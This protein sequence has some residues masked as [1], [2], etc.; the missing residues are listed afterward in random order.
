MPLGWIILASTDTP[1]ASTPPTQ[2]ETER[3]DSCRWV[4][5]SISMLEISRDCG[6]ARGRGLK[7]EQGLR[8]LTE[9]ERLSQYLWANEQTTSGWLAGWLAGIPQARNA[10][11]L[12]R[13]IPSLSGI[14]L[15]STCNYLL[16]SRKCINLYSFI[17]GLIFPNCFLL[18]LKSRRQ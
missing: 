7:T 6:K 14:N 3:E 12:W 5:C 4:C 16:L 15:Q 8:L 9:D 17:R 10:S 18:S 2:R 13:Q 11:R 1:T